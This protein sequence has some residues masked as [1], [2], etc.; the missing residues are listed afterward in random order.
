MKRPSS[1]W[2]LLIA[3]LTSLLLGLAVPATA[4]ADGIPDP[5]FGVVEAHEAPA[6]ATALGAGWTRIRFEWNS[7][8]RNDASQWTMPVSDQTLN[9][10]LASGR[11]VVGL[12]V[13]TPGWATDVSAGAGVPRGLYLPVDDP[14]NLWAGFVRRIVGQYA[15]RIDHWT[16]WNE[17]EIPAGSPDMSWGG[18]VEDY[19]R[20]LQ[21]A[22]TVA[23]RT[24]P[25]AVIHLAAV[26]HYHDPHWFGRFIEAVVTLPG[27]AENGYYFDVATLHLYHEPEKIH[28]ITAHYAGMMHGHGLRKP[29][30]IAETN[31]YLS[32]A[33]EEQQAFFMFQALSLE[34]AAGAQRIA[35]YKM[36]DAAGDAAADPE[37]FG[38]VRMDGSRRPAFTA[39][40][41]AT[42]YLAGFRGGSWDRRDE[43]A[44]VTI[45]RQAS[46]TTVLWSRGPEPQRAMVPA[47]TTQALLVDVWGSA[48]YVYPERGYFYVDLP[49]AICDQGCAI[50]GSPM[51][52]IEQAP[53][54][55]ETAPTPRSPTPTATPPPPTATAEPDTVPT[56]KVARPTAVPCT[57]PSPTAT[58]SVTLSAA[59]SPTLRAGT[60][61]TRTPTAS[62]TQRASSTPAPSPYASPTDTPSPTSAPIAPDTEAWDRV[63]ILIGVLVLSLGGVGIAVRGRRA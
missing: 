59:L 49:G 31:A 21:V 18:S 7:I 53:V 16:I 22:H 32:R 57:T 58:P 27:A 20:L 60:I 9:R 10:E 26:S 46:T 48:R 45:D 43:I 19:V 28:D 17:P 38:L 34:I 30:W 8:Q 24:N 42:T 40:R 33:T 1:A 62:P 35:V 44:M 50:G 25:N 52:L 41:I 47:R 3:L 12:L 29:L 54:G 6:A 13:T 51:M 39:Y 36:A 4:S 14:N 37:P 11:Q 61:E 56:P 23:K 55:A 15:G 2:A 5:R 63:W